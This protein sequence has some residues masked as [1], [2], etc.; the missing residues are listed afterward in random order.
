MPTITKIACMDKTTLLVGEAL[1]TN[2]V[3]AIL[4]EVQTCTFTDQDDIICIPN[5]CDDWDT[6]SEEDKQVAMAIATN[7]FSVLIDDEDEF[8]SEIAHDGI[9]IQSLESMYY[10][11]GIASTDLSTTFLKKQDA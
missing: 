2:D 9:E 4:S 5:I 7:V 8:L 11:S 10:P 6:Y 3:R 1:L